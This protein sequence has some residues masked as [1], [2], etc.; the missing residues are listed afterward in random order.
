MLPELVVRLPGM[1][2][3]AANFQTPIYRKQ[4]RFARVMPVLTLTRSLTCNA[5]SVTLRLL[6]RREKKV[7]CMRCAVHVKGGRALW[8][9]Q[10]K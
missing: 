2:R 5:D 1:L 9:K 7:C 6:P 10:Q 4:G 8:C 3:Q